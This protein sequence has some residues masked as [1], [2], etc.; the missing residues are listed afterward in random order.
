MVS[1]EPSWDSRVGAGTTGEIPW[2]SSDFPAL[3]QQISVP[4]DRNTKKSSA[5]PQ[6]EIPGAHLESTAGGDNSPSKRADEGGEAGDD[7]TI[8]RILLEMAMTDERRHEHKEFIVRLDGILKKCCGRDAR[9]DAF[10]S[11]VSG[12]ATRDSDL[13]ITLNPGR[14]K[15]LTCD[16]KRELLKSLSKHFR[17]RCHLKSFA[18]LSA[19]VPVVQLKDPTTG[20]CA[21]LSV[22]ND[23]PVFKSQLFKDYSSI[24]SRFRPLIMLVKAWAKA[25]GINSAPQGTL[26]SFGYSV[27]VLHYLQ[28]LQPPILPVLTDAT[29]E[30]CGRA[31]QRALAAG[32]PGFLVLTTHCPRFVGEVN[33]EHHHNAARVL[34]DWGSDNSSTTAALFAAFFEYYSKDPLDP[35]DNV[36]RNV[37][38]SAAERIQG[39]FTR[40]HRIVCDE[41]LAAVLVEACSVPTKN[42]RRG[43]RKEERSRQNT[44]SEGTLEG[45]AGEER[46]LSEGSGES[47]GEG[48]VGDGRCLSRAR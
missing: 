3:G 42:Q 23:L 25:R 22:Q 1:G 16:E 26:N 8:E 34:T 19:R 37:G 13:D 46:D 41:G 7:A 21:D 18:V 24:D 38:A 44:A 10:G 40:A 30:L 36:S 43:Q 12:F 15:V 5:T 20:V 33:V 27:L 28:H 11:T 47:G 45:A 9:V 35:N 4:K 39:E 2:N 6:L 29:L 32:L 14:G 17:F 31:R 48:H